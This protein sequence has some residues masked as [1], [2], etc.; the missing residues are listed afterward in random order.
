MPNKASTAR[1]A[2]LNMTITDACR[3]HLAANQVNG[4]LTRLGIFR[5]LSMLKYSAASVFSCFVIKNVTLFKA[6]AVG[7]EGKGKVFKENSVCQNSLF[8]S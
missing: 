8:L 3:A 1:S 2:P 4:N 6:P 5:I 7:T